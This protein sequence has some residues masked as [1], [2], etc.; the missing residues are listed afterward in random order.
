MTTPPM[1]FPAMVAA[2]RGRIRE[3]SVEDVRRRQ[4][5]GEQFLL[6][7]VREDGEWVQ[8]RL[9]GATH[10]GRGVLEP[11]IGKVAADPATPIV[12]YCASGGRSAL[13][14]DALQSLG[15]TNVASLAGGITAWTG[16]GNPVER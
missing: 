3:T 16:A 13:A 2:A 8:G 5:A 10:I 12:L 1:T 15:Y 4:Q 14:A 9:P 6:I 11:N 7:D